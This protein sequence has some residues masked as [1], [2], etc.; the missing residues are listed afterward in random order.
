MSEYNKL[1]TYDY[2]MHWWEGPGMGV[3][4]E[5]VSRYTEQFKRWRMDELEFEVR[6]SRLEHLRGRR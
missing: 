3:E 5:D 4:G 2:A 1:A 6:P